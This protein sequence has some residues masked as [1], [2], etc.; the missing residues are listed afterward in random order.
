MYD[1]EVA[2]AKEK[3]MLDNLAEVSCVEVT[4]G[5]KTV[6]L[7]NV[8]GGE[9]Y[10]IGY[11][12]KGKSA[13]MNIFFKDAKKKYVQPS[14]NLIYPDDGRGVVRVPDGGVRGTLVFSAKNRPGEKTLFENIRI[15][16]IAT[17]EKE[18]SK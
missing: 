15:Y 5:Y 17:E 4:N 11:D 13:K 14:I 7:K 12:A 3:G 16:R 10:A 1:I 2:A 6:S 8:K 9:W 18:V